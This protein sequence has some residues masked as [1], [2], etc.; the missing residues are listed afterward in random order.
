M[1]LLSLE[2]AGDEMLVRQFRSFY[3]E[4][5]RIC[6]DAPLVDN[7]DGANVMARQVAR[8]IENFIELQSLEAQRGGS[9]SEQQALLEARYIKVALADEILLQRDWSGREVWGQHLLEASMFQT[10]VAGLKIFDNIKQL[11][12]SRE[13]AHRALAQIYLFTLA[14][15]FQGQY[16]GQDAQAILSGLR[17]ELFQFVFQRPADL[18]GR[19]RVLSNQ[20]YSNTLSHIAPRRMFPLNRWKFI[21]VGGL[22]ALMA[23][24]ELLWLWPTWA[25][26][27]IVQSGT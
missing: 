7:S 20:P 8:Q 6:N 19:D 21:F 2:S 11:L 1:S 10:S 25:I 4:I 26:R 27:Q 18:T 23:I 13:P 16:R 22:V 24:S 5:D 14:L 12:R 17:D 9:R 15:G 3:A